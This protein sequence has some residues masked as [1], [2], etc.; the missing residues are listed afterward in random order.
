MSSQRGRRPGRQRDREWTP[1][2]RWP[3]DGGWPDEEPRSRGRVVQILLSVLAAVAV[4]VALGVYGLTRLDHGSSVTAR[5]DSAT[6][7]CA[8]RAAAH[9][10]AAKCKS[11]SP[12]A[13]GG[14]A[15][16]PSATPSTPAPHRTGRRRQRPRPSARPST[17]APAPAP[18]RTPRP[19]PKPSPARPTTAPP[20]TSSGSAASQVL[21]LINQARA[22]AGLAAY[23]ESSG[24]DTSSRRHTMVMA[25]GCGLSHQCPGEPALGDRLTAA[26]VSWTSAGENIGEGGPEADTTAA[27]AKMAVGLTQDMLNERPP[28]DGHRLNILSASFHHIGI[29]VFRD[30]GGT[31]WM[32]QDFS[33]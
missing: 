32:T 2:D 19:A 23:S 16:P 13:N 28:D 10:A 18:T 27:I 31:V 4:V 3:Q 1:D 12:D 14:S 25:G 21:S 22:Q 20:G 9:G 24:L 8:A 17:H 30:S 6:A 26:G 15:A 5:Q 11:A 33:N 29:C 7:P